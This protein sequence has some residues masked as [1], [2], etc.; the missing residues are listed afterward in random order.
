[1]KRQQPV[2][3]YHSDEAVII[4][5]LPDSSSKSIKIKSGWSF[6]TGS[7]ETTRLCIRAL[8]EV[9]K[10]KKVN[11][12]LDIGCGSGVLSLCAAAMGAGKV[13]GIDIE[14]SIVEEAGVNARNNNLAVY[15]DFSTKKVSDLDHKFDIII[16][17]ILLETIEELLPQILEKIEKNGFFIASG[18]RTEE[19]QKA[20]D[21]FVNYG[22]ELQSQISETDWVAITLSL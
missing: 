22:F 15:T 2:F 6:G 12:L 18:I 10:H 1:M 3:E 19:I 20:T 9:F 8:E 21:L 7:H 4:F 11:K 5:S 17:N 16:A 14:P 13:I